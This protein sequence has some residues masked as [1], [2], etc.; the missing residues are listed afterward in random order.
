M[1]DFGPMFRKQ[2]FDNNGLPLAGGQ[3]FTYAAGTTT[4]LA[5]YTDSSGAT[6][7]ANPIIL[8]SA[9]VCQYWLGPNTYK[10]ILQDSLGD[11]LQTIDN[12]ESISEQINSIIANA[13]PF[14]KVTMTFAQFQAASTS[15]SV[16][17]FSIPAGNILSN[18]IIK[19]SI[20]FSGTSITDVNAQ[21]GP[22]GVPDQIIGDFDVFQSV[23]DAAF[24][25]VIAGFIGSFANPTP[26]LLKLTSAGANLSALTV[27]SVDIYY[28]Y[29]PFIST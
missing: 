28:Q 17:A 9:G 10:F 5:T 6:P 26:I 14:L 18:V 2:F 8:D 11:V 13:V 25:N 29:Q 23:S 19:H 16:A 12:V 3:I 4:P 1:F 20:A 27:G 7:N 15:E 22:S 24:D 21:L